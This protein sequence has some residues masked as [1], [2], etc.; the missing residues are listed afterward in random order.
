MSITPSLETMQA[1]L[2]RLRA[3]VVLPV[4]LGS[5]LGL[6]SGEERILRHLLRAYPNAVSRATLHQEIVGRYSDINTFNVVLSRLRRK[7]AGTR[8]LVIREKRS[9]LVLSDEGATELYYM[10]GVR[11]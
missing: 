11:A 9:G 4:S 7:L 8:I 10:V 2:E 6:T 5:R 1:E 3:L